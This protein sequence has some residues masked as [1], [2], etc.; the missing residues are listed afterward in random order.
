MK[1]IN[2]REFV[3]LAAAVC[4]GCAAG[5]GRGAWTGATTFDVGPAAESAR[6]AGV[7]GRWEEKGGFFLVR[8]GS[9]LIAVSSE[10]THKACDV[11]A[12][13]EGYSCECHGSRFAPGGKVLT[14]PARR[15]LPRFGISVNDSGHVVVDRTRVFD[16]GRWDEPAS[17]VVIA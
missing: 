16:E 6:L 3:V 13:R 8:E 2:R 12:D 9:R 7:D 5:G 11:T 10:C 14:G 17:F 4:S 15:S 1:S